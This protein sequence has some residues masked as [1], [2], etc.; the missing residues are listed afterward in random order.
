M[1]ANLSQRKL[2]KLWLMRLKK[3]VFKMIEGGGDLFEEIRCIIDFFFS[4]LLILA[5]Q[6]INYDNIFR[7]SSTTQTADLDP[8]RKER[9][10]PPPTPVEWAILAWVIG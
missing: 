8:D 4:V 5:S 9:R 10:G 2:E 7:G 1:K 6:R 3:N